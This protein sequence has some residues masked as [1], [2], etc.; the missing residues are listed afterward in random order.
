MND[1]NA[2]RLSFHLSLHCPYRN[3]ENLFG[4]VGSLV[5]AN[6]N[7]KQPDLTPGNHTAMKLTSRS[8]GYSTWATLGLVA[9]VVPEASL[10]SRSRVPFRGITSQV[11]L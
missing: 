10:Y 11:F 5:T 7:D 3:V 6:L 9:F 1:T 2:L 4:N 8:E